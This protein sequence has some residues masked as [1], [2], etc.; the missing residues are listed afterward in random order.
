MA[1]RRDRAFWCAILLAAHLAVV[2]RLAHAQSAGRDWVVSSTGPD[3]CRFA[4]LPL[5]LVRDARSSTG[6]S[7]RIEVRP[8]NR[9]EES[10]FDRM[11][12][13]LTPKAD[14]DAITSSID[15]VLGEAEDYEYDATVK[16]DGV[17][18]RS[19]RAFMGNSGLLF[20]E[21]P[22]DDNAL[23]GQL[24]GARRIELRVSLGG[25]ELVNDVF[26]M[27]SLAT[28]SAALRSAAWRCPG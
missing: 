28:A 13:T 24:A 2:P 11:R 20:V 23:K 1:M 4:A 22:R 6:F 16:V 27:P 12:V 26:D 14:G 5:E 3:S 7:A 17:N 15:F 18:A 21:F 10:E 19:P 25:E 8:R 9:T